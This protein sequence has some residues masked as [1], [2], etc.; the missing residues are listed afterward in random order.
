LTTNPIRSSAIAAWILLSAVSGAS[1]AQSHELRISHQ[2][3]ADIDARDKAARLFIAAVNKLA[4]HL[5]FSLYPDSSLKIKVIE[6]FDAMAAGELE[7]S[8]YPLVY[9]SPKIPEFA[10][11][12]FPFI[13]ADLDMAMQLKGTPFHSKLQTIAESHGVRILTWWWLAGGLASREREIR[14]PD[15]VKGL[16]VR[17]P[18]PSFDRMFTLAGAQIAQ[19]MPSSDITNALRDGKLDAV[20]TSLE[21][22]AGFRIQD[23]SKS[24]TIGG[25]GIFMS[26]QPLMISQG[27]WD[28]LTVDEKYALEVAAEKS[29][30]YFYGLQREAEQQTR[31]AFVQAGAKIHPLAL[32]EYEAWLRIAKDTAWPEYR[33]LSPA[34]DELFVA[35]L[36]SIIHSDTTDRRSQVPAPVRG[37]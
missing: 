10:I 37:N 8:V 19:R 27:V 1:V 34:A 31:D 25:I 17:L 2:F 9:A 21:S 12:L 20:M 3:K 7:M 32:D 23:Y 18:D 24:A 6:Q 5:K 11:T 36:T 30:Q 15:S 29:D 33:K 13:P 4:P 22:L 26:F 35:L 28:G 16:R 14:A